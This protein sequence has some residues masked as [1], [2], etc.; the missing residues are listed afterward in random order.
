M[1]IELAY[2][3][4]DDMAFLNSMLENLHIK[5][6]ARSIRGI[7]FYWLQDL[8]SGFDY[9]TSNPDDFD[10]ELETCISARN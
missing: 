10:R 3:Q 2:T 9:R 7:I 4:P 8:E 5:V 1:T 6:G